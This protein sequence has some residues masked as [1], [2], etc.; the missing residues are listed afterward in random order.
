MAI[1]IPKK[2]QNICTNPRILLFNIFVLQKEQAFYAGIILD[3][4]R[5]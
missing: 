4:L 2:C 5:C 1:D 3:K